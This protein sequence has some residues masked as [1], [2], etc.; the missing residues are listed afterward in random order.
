MLAKLESY[1]NLAQHKIPS[2][3]AREIFLLRM[4]IEGCLDVGFMDC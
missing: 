2:G 1:P 3:N 4:G